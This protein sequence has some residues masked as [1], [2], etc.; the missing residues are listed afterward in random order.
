MIQEHRT[1]H[2]E[3]VLKG[4]LEMELIV[5]LNVRTAIQLLRSVWV[6]KNVKVSHKDN[7]LLR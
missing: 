2:A 1:S 6:L 3:V 7:R 4:M 5:N